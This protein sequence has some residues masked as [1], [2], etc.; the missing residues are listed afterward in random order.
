MPVVYVTEQGA[1]VGVAGER[2]V[3][4]KGR[5]VLADARI[6]DCGQVVLMGNVQV[7]S[8]AV[9]ALLAGGVEVLY[10]TRGG[11]FVGRLAGGLGGHVALR[12]AQY[13]RFVDEASALA[14]ARQFIRGKVRNMTVLLLR[15]QRER[16]DDAIAV[17]LGR[18]RAA[19]GS[20]EGASTTDEVMGVEGAATRE[21]FGAFGRLIQAEGIAFTARL[22]RPPPDPVNVLLSFGYTLLAGAIHGMVEQAGLDPYLGALHAPERGR[23]SLVLDLMEE[24]RPV[25]VDATVLRVLNTKAIGARDFVWAAPE[26]AAEVEDEWEREAAETSAAGTAAAPTPAVGI[27]AGATSAA[28]IPAAPTPAVAAS[29]AGT[30]PTSTVGISAAATSAAGTA[31]GTAPGAEPSTAFG[32]ALGTA[33]GATPGTASGAALGVAP[34]AAAS[35]VTDWRVAHSQ[36]A[37]AAERRIVFTRVGVKKWLSA[38]ERRMEEG[39][40]YVR[41]G[42]RLTYRQVLR[43]Q[44][45]LLARHLLGEDEYEPFRYR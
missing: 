26:E 24:F 35:V 2:L 16:H 5:S 3:V 15:H 19:L 32:A 42:R 23:P 9:R 12:R 21:Y 6:A 37:G 20:L 36:A 31:P 33:F 39:I 27:S 10:L 45:Y 38:F 1:E 18:L 17:A 29:A 41:Q 13:R 11:R 22:R 43:E 40:E 25:V 44:V 8:Q 34:G 14:L 30:A 7:T 4:R 28:G